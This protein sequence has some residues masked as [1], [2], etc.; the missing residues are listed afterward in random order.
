MSEQANIPCP[1]C[2]EQMVQGFV[3][4]HTYGGVDLGAWIEGPPKWS[5]WSGIQFRGHTKI[6]I[7]A[8]RCQG[9]GF[10]EFYAREE[11]AAK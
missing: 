6:P 1:K 11:F 10:L 8:F 2:Q 9:C 3:L 5:F 4:D 7:A